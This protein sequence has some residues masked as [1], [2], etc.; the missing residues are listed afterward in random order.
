MLEVSRE[1]IRTDIIQQFPVEERFIKLPIENYLALL[2][3]Y[4]KDANG[5]LTGETGLDPIPPQIAL[6]NALNNPKYRFITAA[7][8][9]RT[10]KTEIA[11]IIAQLVSFI[12][13]ANV[14]IISPNY[15]LSS[16]S[17][18]LQ[19]KFLRLFDVEVV[20][21]NA[22]DK[23]IELMNGSSI[24]MASVSQADSAVGRSYDFIIFDEC[25][26]DE[27]GES[28]FNIQLRP[29][30]D[31]PNS[32]VVF[33]STPRGKNW[34]YEF[35]KRGFS[36]DFPAWASIHSD[37][38]SNP[39]ANPDDIAEAK[40][41]MSK[42]EFEQEYLASFVSLQ[43]QIFDYDKTNTLESIDLDSIDVQDIIAGIDF[44]FRDATAMVIIATD[45]KTYYVIDEYVSSGKTTAT[46]A[47]KIKKF[48]DKYDIDF[49][50]ID[51]SA[52][53]TKFDLAMN[54]D[55]S[56]INAKKSILDGIGYMASIIDNNRLK[57]D[58][59]CKHTLTMLDT[60][61]WDTREGLLKER[62]KHDENSHIADAL[63]YACYTH[64]HNVDALDS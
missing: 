3:G 13:G 57:V 21:S 60:Y 16:I 7:L 24:R 1:D 39:R 14:L 6:I 30:L 48:I 63:R 44:G 2:P 17:W 31:K 37:Y 36:N 53:Q 40:A 25:A 20:K 29:T 26:L 4:K 11:N 62:P 47:K 43:G 9:R 27:K 50:Y 32:K 58:G 18:D 46:H 41:S 15:N 38:L 10:G 23:V 8:S 19:R 55:I 61:V 59:K 33:I 42:A 34:F 28:A 35:Y 45:G 51:S 54:F 22:K 12:P 49:I 56:T 5:M 52:A 64:S